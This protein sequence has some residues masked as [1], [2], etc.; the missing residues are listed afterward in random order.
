MK[1]QEV[2]NGED[3]RFY[4]F[5]EDDSKLIYFKKPNFIY[6]FPEKDYL[7]SIEFQYPPEGIETLEIYYD[8]QD[9]FSVEEIL[10]EEWIKVNDNPVMLR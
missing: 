1:L 10:S 7:R 3:D 5:R 6:R 9:I 2:L 8:D 4:F